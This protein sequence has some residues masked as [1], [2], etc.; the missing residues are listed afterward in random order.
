MREIGNFQ[1]NFHERSVGRNIK[2]YHGK[3]KDE[4]KDYDKARK[5]WRWNKIYI[6]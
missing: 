3:T 4:V 5:L 1:E 6:C 2:T